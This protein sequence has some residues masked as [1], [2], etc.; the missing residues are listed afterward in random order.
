MRKA[1]GVLLCEDRQH[2]AFARR[3]LTVARWSTQ[4]LRVVR[5]APGEGAGAGFVLRQLPHEMRDR[6]R[7]VSGRSLIAVV[8]GDA[9]GYRSRIEQLM[10]RCEA[11]GAPIRDDDNVYLLAPS[12]NIETWFAYLE[13][14]AV[15]E[16]VA[17]PRLRRERDCQRHVNELHQMCERNELRQPAPPSLERACEEYR[18]FRQQNA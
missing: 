14:D 4:E 2:E 11:E 8:D 13:G 18:R 3:F 10:A 16:A 6:R 7:R 9:D 15:N 1:R 5:P 17:Y 12:R